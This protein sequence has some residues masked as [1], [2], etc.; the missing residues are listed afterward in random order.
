MLLFFN[1]QNL[2]N[3]GGT[4]PSESNDVFNGSGDHTQYGHTS[5]P[6]GTTDISVTFVVPPNYDSTSTVTL[7]ILWYRLSN[8]AGGDVQFAAEHRGFLPGTD[9]L[10]TAG[11]TFS[12]SITTLAAGGGNIGN[13]H[14]STAT[15]ALTDGGGGTPATGDWY[16][17]GFE[18]GNAASDTYTFDVAVM[19]AMISQ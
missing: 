3:N 14:T 19:G 16:Y 15:F 17:I 13:V 9:N 2:Q 10:V 6:A 5:T 1:A 12:T 8:G 11:S 18:R 7:R 4:L